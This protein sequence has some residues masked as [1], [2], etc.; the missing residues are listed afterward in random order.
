MYRLILSKRFHIRKVLFMAI[1]SDKYSVLYKIRL[2]F[3]V[4]NEVLEM[5]SSD[6]VSIAYICNYDTMTHPIIRV[7]LYTDLSNIQMLCDDPDDIYVKLSF[8]GNMY[9]VDNSSQTVTPVSRASSITFQLKGYIETK[10]IPSSKYDQYK[11]GVK[12]NDQLSSGN[13]FPFEVYCYNAP[14]IN[15]T[16]ST[17]PAI[18]KNMSTLTAM[19]QMLSYLGLNDLPAK[20]TNPDNQTKYDQILIP[21][22]DFMDALTFLDRYYGIYKKGTQVFFDLDALYIVPSDV[23]KIPLYQTKFTEPILISSA[24]ANTDLVGYAKENDTYKIAVI[25]KNV[26][27]LTETDIEKVINGSFV[28]DLDFKSGKVSSAELDKKL[29][30]ENKIITPHVLHPYRNDYVSDM[31]AS[32]INERITRV[33]LSTSGVDVFSLK[34]NTHYNL[35]FQ[36]PIRGFDIDRKYRASYATHVFSNMDSDLFQATSTFKLCSN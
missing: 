7:R 11:D 10:N 27:V 5:S 29:Q 18:Y 35:I 16:K 13:K 33:D 26:S 1:Q 31:Y 17:V 12:S 36:T 30:N 34:I 4:N 32:M 20:I 23:E 28:S 22:L 6:I 15:K 2:N 3:I 8:D 25:D 19:Q 9:K 24:S 21:N 14:I